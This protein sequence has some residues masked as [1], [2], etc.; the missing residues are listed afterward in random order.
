M[1]NTAEQIAEQARLALEQVRQ[2]SR[3]LVP[4]EVA[5]DRLVDAIRD[6][7]STTESL[8]GIRVTVTTAMQGAIGDT[9][10]ATE[11]LRITQ[12]AVT[13]AL[14]H[15]QASTIRIELRERAGLVTLMIVDDGIGIP[16]DLQSSGFGLRIMQERASSVGALLSTSP[17]PMG[18]T[19][20]TCLLRPAIIPGSEAHS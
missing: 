1:A 14:K 5:P 19:V 2:I 13:N 12:E 6:L 10:V 9:R 20:V 7:A 3:G 16:K 15:A 18:G 11:L 17:S 8:H 4:L